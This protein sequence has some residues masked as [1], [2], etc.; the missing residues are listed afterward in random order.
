MLFI[1]C[2]ISGALSYLESRQL[3]HRDV[4]TRNCL[5]FTD[6]MIK[7]TDIAMASPMYSTYYFTEAYLPIRW[8]SPELLQ[9]C[10]TLVRVRRFLQAS[11]SSL[12]QN[13]GNAYSVKSDVY[14]FGVTLYEMM[15]TCRIL[16]FAHLSDQELLL[17]PP[18][19]ADLDL[20]LIDT[21]QLKELVDLMFACLRTNNHERPIFQ[22]IHRFLYQ[23][24]KQS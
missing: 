5:V 1:T 13:G 11:H 23:Q 8:M 21:D 4:S 17:S 18:S 22:D 2:Q 10:C 9:V 24:Q 12:F 3:V 16:P 14:S 6:Y 7:L 19:P 15:T 20:S